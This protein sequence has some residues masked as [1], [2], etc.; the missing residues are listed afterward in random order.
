MPIIP[1]HLWGPYVLP[2]F[3]WYVSALLSWHLAKRLI[4]LRIY[5]FFNSNNIL[6]NKYRHMYTWKDWGLWYDD[7]RTTIFKILGFNVTL[8]S[9]WDFEVWFIQLINFRWVIIEWFEEKELVRRFNNFFI[10][11]FQIVPNHAN[12]SKVKVWRS[13]QKN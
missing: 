9:G 12:A 6:Y 8:L 5:L 11:N 3:Y 13:T 2:F 10:K 4:Y 1:N 7:M